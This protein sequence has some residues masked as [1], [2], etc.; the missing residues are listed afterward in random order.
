MS[1]LA[2]TFF[3]Q[4]ATSTDTAK[5]FV[6][7]RIQETQ[8]KL[9]SDA[10][11]K[12]A[13]HLENIQ[14]I[15]GAA[16]AG[17]MGLHRTYE[18]GVGAVNRYRKYVANG[19]K[20]KAQ[21]E[22]NNTTRDSEFGGG[23]F[24]ERLG[25]L[26]AGVNK[27]ASEATQEVEQNVLQKAVPTGEKFT[28]PEDFPDVPGETGEEFRPEDAEAGTKTLSSEVFVRPPNPQISITEDIPDAPGV[29]P[30]LNIGDPY[31]KVIGKAAPEETAFGGRGVVGQEDLQNLGD[32]PTLIAGTLGSRVGI[33][34]EGAVKT[35]PIGVSP[36]STRLE[37]G[38]EAFAGVKPSAAGF[39]TSIEDKVSGVA[40][41]LAS[42][43]S[44]LGDVGALGSQIAGQAIGGKTGNILSDAGTG[45]QG[46]K[47]ATSLGSK[48]SSIVGEGV[49]E[50]AG[51]IAGTAL[52]FLGPVGEVAG[53]GVML[54]GVLHDIFGKKKNTQEDVSPQSIVGGA[55]NSVGLDEA[56]AQRASGAVEGQTLV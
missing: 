27:G 21:A 6:N 37:Q 30:K 52:S 3:S 11:E 18:T 51:E 40:E 55:V 50:G 25:R 2:S 35:V 17:G 16:A 39:G 15:G 48:I 34:E 49:G 56:S 5:N 46:V 20:I 32:R 4:S 28:K 23:S 53:A 41:S 1:Q 43:A 42:G 10:K 45:L 13:Q 22:A 26:K 9:I 14:Q 36:P 7:Q 54:Y 19:Q 8:A 12:V 24:E 47:G 29:A 38:A 33:G 44:K 31:D